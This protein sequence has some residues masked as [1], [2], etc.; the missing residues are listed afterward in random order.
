MNELN[1]N[2]WAE[3]EAM[4]P[5]D[6]DDEQL[7]FANAN[8]IIGLREARPKI[9]QYCAEQVRLGKLEEVENHPQ[10][11]NNRW[12]DERLAQLKDTTLL[13]GGQK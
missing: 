1:N 11:T 7:N 4:F 6:T 5:V 12:R 13:E 9:E 8:K 3:I 2:E 10:K